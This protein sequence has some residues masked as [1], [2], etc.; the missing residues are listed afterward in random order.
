MGLRRPRLAGTAAAVRR[1]ARHSQA[2][3][4]ALA[5]VIGAAAGL[6][7]VAFRDAITAVQRRT[8][9]AGG[10]RLYDVIAH[11]PAW[12]VVAVPALGGLVIGLFVRFALPGRRPHGVADVIEAAALRSGRMSGLTGIAAAASCIASIGVGASVGREGPVVHLGA[13]VGSWMAG[14]LGLGRSLA[15]TLLGCGAAAAIAASFNAPIAGVFFALEVVIG[16]YA[17]S[18]FAPV[19]LSS[20]IATMIARIHYGNF[21]AFAVPGHS[22]VSY[23]EFPSFALLGIVAAV[24]AIALL[25]SIAL[26]QAQSCRLPA[27]AVAGPALAGLAVGCIALVMPHVLGVGYGATDAALRGQLGLWLLIALAVAKTAATALSLGGGF[28]GGIF[29]PSLFL[30][31]MVGGAFGIVAT[32]A[33]PE[34]SSGTEA[35]TLIGMGAV[36]AATLGAPISTIL[37]IFELTSNYGLTIAVML[38]V[39]IAVAITRAV[40][41]HS[42]F[43]WQLTLRGLNLSSGREVGLLAAIHVADVARTDYPRVSPS[44]TLAE[45]RPAIA[46]APHNELF[47]VDNDGRLV[48][49]ITLADLADAAFDAS[50]DTLLNAADVARRRPTVLAAGDGL[51]AA[52]RTM[53]EAGE[54]HVAVV[55]DRAGMRMVGV[56]HEIDAMAA[57]NRALIAARAEE[58]GEG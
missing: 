52:I 24:Q 32:D 58:R 37:I 18:A 23:L 44:A 41:G 39:V 25:R 19:V 33:F 53:E 35:Y 13:V 34:L 5:V 47:V 14:R 15:V 7:S 1:I 54:E 46:H 43:T 8:F 9:G 20:V 50:M 55:A 38:A 12:R 42:Y 27:P 21:P 17:L 11:L 30:G 22:I 3:L 4:W 10:E 6:G 57:Y 48:G 29:S 45:L 2:V 40:G 36:S 49:T 31:A 56:V 28:P 26:V 51:N 16:H